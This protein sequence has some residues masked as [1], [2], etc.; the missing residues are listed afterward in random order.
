MKTIKQLLEDLALFA[1][2][3]LTAC[4]GVIVGVFHVPPPVRKFK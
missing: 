2:L 1:V 3:A 4:A